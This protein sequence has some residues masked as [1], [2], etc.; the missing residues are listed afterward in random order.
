MERH[1]TISSYEELKNKD[2]IESK[3][4]KYLMLKKWDK[5]EKRLEKFEFCT[6]KKKV[7]NKRQYELYVSRFGDQLPTELNFTDGSGQLPIHTAALKGAPLSLIKKIVGLD[8]Q[9]I[10]CR[11]V[12]N[13]WYP[14][15]ILCYALK[16]GINSSEGNLAKLD[17]YTSEMEEKILWMIEKYPEALAM[18][19][20]DS[21]TPLHIVLEHKP[22]HRIVQKM[23]QCAG[24]RILKL[25]DIQQQVPLHIA[26]DYKANKHVCD[27]LIDNFP[28]ATEVKMESNYLPLHF[29]AQSGCSLS[30]LQKL[31]YHFPTALYTTTN[32][33]HSAFHLLLE[34]YKKK[35]VYDTGESKRRG[36]ASIEDM[37]K[38]M[39]QTYFD[40]KV[41]QVGHLKAK[42]SLVKIIGKQNPHSKQSMYELARHKIPKELFIY[43]TNLKK[44]RISLQPSN[45]NS[46][47][48][49]RAKQKKNVRDHSGIRKKKKRITSVEREILPQ[50]P[51]SSSS[52]PGDDY[53]NVN[54]EVE[55]NHNYLEIPMCSEKISFEGSRKSTSKKT[56]RVRTDQNPR[57]QKKSRNDVRRTSDYYTNESDSSYVLDDYFKNNDNNNQS[58]DDEIIDA[59]NKRNGTRRKSKNSNDGASY[60]SSDD[61]LSKANESFID[62]P[63]SNTPIVSP[64]TKIEQESDPES[65]SE[66]EYDPCYAVRRAVRKI[67]KDYYD[68]EDSFVGTITV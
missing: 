27:L 66:Q 68:D 17:S 9:C 14:L 13:G 49:S 25:R 46:N 54:A 8:R 43:L 39:L 23:I 16:L 55:S 29:A 28:A 38:T 57:P 10:R 33:G 20:S 1:E 59:K 45:L 30:T 65:R 48:S 51:A 67:K 31:L 52:S 5:A 56:S 53:D 19:D 58:F 60:Y 32:A 37:I 64:K 61:N 21:S 50:S 47:T 18:G 2:M 41:R 44:G 15:H 34:D 24:P 12:G 63:D 40:S 3:L 35:F 6:I 11:M 4:R 26:L 42:T 36:N 7:G 62:R 22:S